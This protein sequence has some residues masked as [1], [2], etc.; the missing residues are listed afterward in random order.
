MIWNVPP[1]PP[2]G[3]NTV[4]GTCTSPGTPEE[5]STLIP[6]TGAAPVSVNV[7]VE[8]C[9]AVTGDGFKVTEVGRGARTITDPVRV[10]VPTVASTVHVVSM[11]TG[12]V[13]TVNTALYFP[14]GAVMLSGTEIGSPTLL[15]AILSPPTGAG[16]F[17]KTAPV[18]ETPPVG[19]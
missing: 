17:N 8:P 2:A 12:V 10:T 15:S 1:V 5:M 4:A 13:D 3:T 14:A 19:V 16:P 9:R 18:H 11:A 7:P 6:P